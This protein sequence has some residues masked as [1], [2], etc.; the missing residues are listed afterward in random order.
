MEI[1]I[2]TILSY[3][4]GS[5]S[6]SL[7]LGR[8]KGIDIRKEGSGNAGSTNA[9]RTQ[10][11][12][13]ALT[14]LLIDVLKGIIAVTLIAKFNNSI[15]QVLPLLCGGAVILGHIYPIFFGFKG[16]KG[17]GTAVGVIGVL[18]PSVLLVAIPVWIVFLILTGFVG[19]STMVSS[20]SI[21]LFSFLIERDLSFTI[22]TS[23][24]ALFMIFSHRSNIQRMLKGTENRFEKAMIFRRTN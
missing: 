5:L 24:L 3:L 15:S 16:G 17:A 12:V 22:F 23:V 11:K 13:F 9:Y 18:S 4:I 20:I 14:V 7:I 1:L 19:L 2:K 10:G 6:G 8:I 21:P